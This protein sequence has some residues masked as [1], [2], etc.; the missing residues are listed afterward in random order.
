MK[1]LLAIIVL[2]LFLGGCATAPSKTVQKQL[3]DQGNIKV[4]M[5]FSDVQQIIAGMTWFPIIHGTNTQ[6]L[7]LSPTKASYYE[8]TYY[9]TFK[10][11]PSGKKDLWGQYKLAD[12][13]LSKIWSS[14]IKMYDSYLKIATH[15]KDVS[16]IATWKTDT[17]RYLEAKKNSESSSSSSASS[18]SSNNKNRVAEAKLACADLGFKPK[19]EKFAECA[20]KFVSLDFE[21]TMS[22]KNEPQVVIHKNDVNV[23]DELDS[24]F[25]QQGIIQDT[26]RPANTRTNLRCTSSKTGFGQVVTNCR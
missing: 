6:H 7:I 4:G 14:P 9:Y 18:S 22:A 21:R 12:Y 16:R 2:G 17:L 11:D 26:N 3:I 5:K 24:F 8:E 25:R 13:R 20:L 1:K 19:T 10:A 15:P 23:W